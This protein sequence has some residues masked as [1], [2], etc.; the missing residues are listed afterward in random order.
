ME[1]SKFFL[2]FPDSQYHEG[3]LLDEYQGKYS[4]CAANKDKDG[5]VYSKW[6]Y[7]Q[8]F[9]E[10]VP[11]DKSLPWKVTLG[12]KAAAKKALLMFADIL[13]GGKGEEDSIPF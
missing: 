11:I 5:K 4:L 7:P 12:D 2:E 6:G 10:K 9:G 3:I 13:D 8:K 1:N